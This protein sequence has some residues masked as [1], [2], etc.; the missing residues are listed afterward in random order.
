MGDGCRIRSSAVVKNSIL[1]AEVTVGRDLTV[2]NSI[3]GEGVAINK[4]VN[5]NSLASET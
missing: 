4:N 3:L 1:W 2:Q 5:N